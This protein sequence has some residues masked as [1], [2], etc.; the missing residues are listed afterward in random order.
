MVARSAPR[1]PLERRG[2]SA[3][4]L[5]QEWKT[6]A[7]E[8]VCCRSGLFHKR[9]AS[10]PA[11]HWSDA[12]PCW[13]ECSFD[14][15]QIRLIIYQECERRGFQP[16]FDSSTV[17]FSQ[18]E[19]GNIL[20]E[21]DAEVVKGLGCSPQK[22]SS[23]PTEFVPK[24]QCAQSVRVGSDVKM[25]GEMMFGNVAMS[26]KGSTLK[27]HQI[28][29]PPQLLL[30][31]VFTLNTGG[32]TSLSG[33][34]S[35]SLLTESFECTSSGLTSS[36]S[37]P[38]LNT[39]AL[40]QERTRAQ[41]SPL[42]MPSRSGR[43]DGDSGIARFAS[44]TSLKVGSPSS[45]LPNIGSFNR[46]FIR[47]QNM[48]LN[49]AL[50]SKRSTEE[51]FFTSD[52][53][54]GANPSRIRQKRI[55]IGII[56]SLSE[57]QEEGRKFEEFFFSHFLLIEGHLNCLRAAVEQAILNCR[58][59][60]VPVQCSHM[61]LQKIMD[62]LYQFRC[63]ITDL[64]V[65]PRLAQPA[66]LAMSSTCSHKSQICLHL[67]QSL[68]ATSE[69]SH[70]QF[71]PALL[72]AVLTH[73]LA[74]VSTVMPSGHVP[75]SN[76]TQKHSSQALDMLA[77]S[78][79]YNPLWAQLG[80]LY[81]CLG[82]PFK[83]ARVVV[84]GSQQ[85][86]VQ[87]VLY[88]LSYF[89]RCSEV[90][91]NKLELQGP[92]L[93]DPE[94]YCSNII[95]SFEPGEVEQSE[96]VVV[97][98]QRHL[99]SCHQHLALHKRR[100][101]AKLQTGLESKLADSLHFSSACGCTDD[102]TTGWDTLSSSG[103]DANSLSIKSSSLPTEASIKQMAHDLGDVS[104]EAKRE[105]TTVP[106]RSFRALC[107]QGEEASAV[108]QSFLESGEVSRSSLPNHQ[109]DKLSL[110]EAISVKHRNSPQGS[111]KV[112]FLI[113]CSLS[114]DSDMESHTQRLEETLR[115]LSFKVD[116]N[117]YRSTV[118]QERN[119]YDENLCTTDK[120]KTESCNM[121]RRLPSFAGGNSLFD[122]YFDDYDNFETKTFHNIPIEQCCCEEVKPV[123]VGTT[124]LEVPQCAAVPTDGSEAC[125]EQT[126]KNTNTCT[127]SDPHLNQRTLEPVNAP[128]L[129]LEEERSLDMEIPRNESSDSAL[130]DSDGEEGVSCRN[131]RHVSPQQVELPLPRCNI[132]EAHSSN[133]LSSFGKSMFGGF[134]P[135]YV[136]DLVLQG[137][138][139]D[140]GLQE[141]LLEDLNHA[142]QH[143]VLE[144]PVAEAVCVLADSERWTVQLMSSQRRGLDTQRLTKDVLVSSLVSHILHST[145]QLWKLGLPA[146]FC[147]MHLEDQLQEIF[148]KSQML[149]EYLKGNERVRVKEL[150]AVL[151]I[152]AS[153]LPLLTAVASTHSPHVAQILL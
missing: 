140:V 78:H 30:S 98:L 145:L 141:R 110:T 125:F 42:D 52:G 111:R 18:K 24:H 97:T 112:K 71:L 55:A 142:V 25:L 88:A 105:K 35:S 149:A 120:A 89:I 66:W 1:G 69:L 103:S 37:F 39:N 17:R 148:R 143:P 87:Q 123:P 51:N 63:S 38:F 119:E 59:I 72:S 31:K 135:R 107:D 58:K 13:P 80:D 79:P 22:L 144:E 86:V 19:N 108:Y 74:W 99:E 3:L 93:L 61:H 133:N 48:S 77:R 26:F 8:N 6:R 36:H 92:G 29:S 40:L 146:D 96:Y 76:F 81:G 10:S 82:C 62:S 137:I 115:P 53:S 90:N 57:S 95:T 54:C 75:F 134:C 100:T 104:A 23:L 34:S 109:I 4:S 21:G 128:K 114:P 60:R 41:S 9:A 129:S 70:N 102:R 132:V 68:N 49:S 85:N 12:E 46:R 44:L 32:S 50:I 91:E 67:L 147:V 116:A 124:G 126:V 138:P 5:G 150:G 16:L 136:P 131:R 83:M 151:G 65:Q 2:Q 11:L 43:E 64:Y 113:G 139:S 130:G 127:S 106:Q 47:S 27:I 122:E 117:G 56:F 118:Q 94:D 45:S 20:V 152:E 14:G 84:I 121:I 153:D 33:S 73:H 28:R 101:N 7:N 15:S